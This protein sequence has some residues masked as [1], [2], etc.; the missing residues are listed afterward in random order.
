MSEPYPPIKATGGSRWMYLIGFVFLAIGIGAGGL[1]G[2]MWWNWWKA[3]SWVE[4]PAWVIMADLEQHRGSKGSATFKVVARYMYNYGGQTREN[5][6][7]G[8]VNMT[9][10][11]GSWHQDTYERL[12]RHFQ[13][14][15]PV[16]CYV[17][18]ENPEE[19][20]LDRQLR[21]GIYSFCL[22][23]ALLFGSFGIGALLGGGDDRQAA[24]RT[25]ELRARFP[26]E[27]WRWDPRWGDGKIPAGTAGSRRALWAVVVYWNAIAFSVVYVA[28][29]DFLPRGDWW[30][31]LSLVIPLAGV[32]LLVAAVRGSIRQRKF[33]GTYLQLDTLPAVPGARLKATL[34]VVGE[35]QAVGGIKAV[36]ECDNTL[37]TRE[38]G[39]NR[40]STKTVWSKEAEL[41]P[42]GAAFG[43]M[44]TRVPIEFEIPADAR[45]TNER[46]LNDK[47]EWKLRVHASVPGVDLKYEF[48]VPVGRP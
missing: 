30:A 45:P 36:L 17:N 21:M 13:Q 18:P 38:H 47:I 40:T 41:E 19:A 22:V 32:A 2:S 7:V 8:L 27:P 42:T 25:H 23:F 26:Q 3:Q 9:D 28:I 1:A 29:R 16:V 20:L 34:V 44:E 37:T 31:A 12:I 6:R 15:Q 11:F 14:G 5:N 39:K 35:F 4:S 24:A 43:Q 46:A 10:N 33:G 48:P